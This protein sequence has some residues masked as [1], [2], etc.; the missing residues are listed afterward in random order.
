MLTF[1]TVPTDLVANIATNAGGIFTDLMPVAVV[2]IGVSLGLVLLTW[3][4]GRFK[5]GK[6][7]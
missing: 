1:I 3:A 4:I 6:G 7:Y 2:V 5:R